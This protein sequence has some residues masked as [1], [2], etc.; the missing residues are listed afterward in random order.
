MCR[1]LVI[2]LLAMFSISHAGHAGETELT[3]RSSSD[4]GTGAS[5]VTIK[6]HPE[7]FVLKEFKTINE[8][9]NTL[10]SFA[11]KIDKQSKP[12]KKLNL[13]DSQQ[14]LHLRSSAAKNIYSNFANSVV[15][16]GNY[17]TE[18]IGTGFLVH[19]SG[20]IVTNWHVTNKADT[21][22][23]WIKPKG[24]LD[25]KTLITTQDPYVGTVVVEDMTTDLAIVKVQ[26]LPANMKVIPF[27]RDSD[28]DIGDRVYAIGH[29]VGYPWTFTEGIVNQIR[30][31]HE[32]VYADKSKHKATLIQ[33]QTP[34][35]PGNS[36]GPL[37]TSNGKLVG[38]NSLGADG[39]NINFAVI[40]KHVKQIL[41]KN[42]NIVKMNPAEPTMKKNYPKAKT[43]DYN[44]N[45]VI[46]T[47]YVDTDKNGIIDTAFIDDNEDGM[48]ESILIDDNENQV[49]EAN[50]IDDDLNGKPDRVI[51]DSDEDKKPDAVGFDY[52]QDGEWDHYKKIA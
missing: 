44:K 9:Y 30:I 35:S 12:R 47:W 1:I 10:Q 20:L 50:I 27:G 18:S 42:P 28:V 31:D 14:K 38:V 11:K 48:I 7:M 21:V 32:W 45:G 36:G 37:F 49:W 29:P 3:L 46:D 33:T 4:V 5:N 51:I 41:K 26:N 25:I 23:V 17:D 52:D 6:I 24:S 43:Q 15:F 39:Q 34:I 19:R 16:I 2:I 40:I 13:I 22:G 8:N